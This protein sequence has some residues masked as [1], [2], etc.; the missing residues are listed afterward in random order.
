MVDEQ[1]KNEI[2]PEEELLWFPNA[3][4]VK[5]IRE[6]NKGKI[7]KK[8]V[9]VAMNQLLESVCRKISRE[10]AK[11][12]YSSITYSD[13]LEAAKPYL[14]L[15]KIEQERRKVIQTLKKVEEDVKYLG[16]ELEEKLQDQDFFK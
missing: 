13:F 10:M 5:L 11:K 14:D 15:A 16:M 1:E 2:K 7:I 6:E 3:R 4:V 8:R 12:P 9:K